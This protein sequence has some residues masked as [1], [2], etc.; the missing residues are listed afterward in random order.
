M[1]LSSAWIELIN[2]ICFEDLSE[3]AIQTRIDY[4]TRHYSL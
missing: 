2:S 4:L 1:M 3:D